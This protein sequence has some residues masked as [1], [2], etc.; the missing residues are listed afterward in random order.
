MNIQELQKAAQNLRYQLNRHLDKNEYVRQLALTLEPI[1]EQA[2]QSSILEPLHSVPGGYLFSE[3]GLD[4]LDD[5]GKAYSNFYV[6]VKDLEDLVEIVR[7][8]RE[9]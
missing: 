8:M 6:Q 3:Y 4:E 1:L 2:E 9:S 7:Q 5:L